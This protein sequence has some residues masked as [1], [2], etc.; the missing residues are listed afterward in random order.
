MATTKFDF[1]A[2][3]NITLPN[4]QPSTKTSVNENVT[5]PLPSFGLFVNY[6]ITPRFQFQTRADFFYLKVGNYEGAMFEYYLGI[7][8]RLFKHFA[9]DVAYDRL[10]ADLQDTSR[11]GFEFDLSYNLVYF[12]GTVYLF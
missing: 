10:A 1:T 3:G 8:Y 7:E 6:A 12:Y 2:Q 4:N 11:G 5:V 9:M